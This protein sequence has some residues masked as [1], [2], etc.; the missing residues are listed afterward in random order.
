MSSRLPEVWVVLQLVST[1]STSVSSLLDWE[2]VDDDE[3][4]PRFSGCRGSPS[5]PLLEATGSRQSCSTCSSSA[6]LSSENLSEGS[7]SLLEADV[8]GSILEPGFL[9]MKL[10]MNLLKTIPLSANVCGERRPGTVLE[11]GPDQLSCP[12]LSPWK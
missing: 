7:F 1:S 11:D 6:L 4:S 3:L 8:K 9:L 10:A 5:G 12:L 2:S